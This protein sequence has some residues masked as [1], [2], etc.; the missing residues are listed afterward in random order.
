MTLMFSIAIGL[1][2]LS[3]TIGTVSSVS[4]LLKCLRFDQST[5][6]SSPGTPTRQS[7]APQ[8]SYRFPS[9]VAVV[10]CTYSLTLSVLVDS[11]FLTTAAAGFHS[12]T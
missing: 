12:P 9:T 8:T 3:L 5:L 1:V 2:S 4:T 11:Q 6:Q 10:A 7:V